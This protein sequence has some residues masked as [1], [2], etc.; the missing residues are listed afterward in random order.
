M[1]YSALLLLA[2]ILPL[3]LGAQ[4]ITFGVVSIGTTKEIRLVG[5]FNDVSVRV[6][7]N[8]YPGFDLTHI[9]TQLHDKVFGEYQGILRARGYHFIPE[10]ELLSMQGF[11]QIGVLIEGISYRQGYPGYPVISGKDQ[12]AF[13][14]AYTFVQQ[15]D[16]IASVGFFM[17][18]TLREDDSLDDIDIEG[19]IEA[20]LTFGAYDEEGNQIFSLTGNG[21]SREKVTALRRGIDAE[22]LQ[23]MCEEAASEAMDDLFVEGIFR[24][25][26]KMEKKI[27][28]Y[29]KKR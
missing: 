4:D 18:F 6:A 7:I 15:H 25:T 14:E 10:E 27:R 21:I 13:K 12:R 20:T 23:R 1:K 19:V 8:N 3:Q 26:K 16:G 5:A 24:N 22:P 11:D 28:K 17:T 2:F 29:V 9:V